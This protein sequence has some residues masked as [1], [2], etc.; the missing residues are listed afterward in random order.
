MALRKASAGGLVV[1]C[2]DATEMQ[3]F[4]IQPKYAGCW[5]GEMAANSRVVA[6]GFL[7]PRATGHCTDMLAC[8]G[9]QSTSSASGKHI[10]V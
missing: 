4:G 1:H 7:N 8:D 10:L 3:H 6:K 5:A 9:A 2:C